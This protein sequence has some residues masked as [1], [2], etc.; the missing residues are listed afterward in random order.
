MYKYSSYK[1]VFSLPYSWFNQ[2]KQYNCKETNFPVF[3]VESFGF[4][5]VS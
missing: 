4:N 2:F 1:K 5:T 3:T